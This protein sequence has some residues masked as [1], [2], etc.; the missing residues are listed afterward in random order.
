MSGQRNE[1]VVLEEM[2]RREKPMKWWYTAP[3]ALT[4][5]EAIAAFRTR[6]G[7]DPDEVGKVGEGHPFSLWCM[8]PINDEESKR[9]GKGV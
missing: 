3:G 6:F 2:E 7:R 4:R 8:G 1:G 5:E 9:L